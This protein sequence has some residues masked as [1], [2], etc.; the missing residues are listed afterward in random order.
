MRLWQ[1]LI[2]SENSGGSPTDD[3]IIDANAQ[4]AILQQVNDLIYIVNLYAQPSDGLSRSLSVPPNNGG[5]G[6]ILGGLG[7]TTVYTIG[8]LIA[9]NASLRGIL[10]YQLKKSKTP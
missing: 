9:L 4:K 5:G 2:L 8:G 6:N 7:S 1:Y 10:A 3:L